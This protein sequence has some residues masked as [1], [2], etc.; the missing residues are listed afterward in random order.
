MERV[1]RRHSTT[2]RMCIDSTMNSSMSGIR[3][4]LTAG[5][6]VLAL[7]LLVLGAVLMHGVI[8]HSPTENS[9]SSAAA[10]SDGHEHGSD[11]RVHASGARAQALYGET[12]VLTTVDSAGCDGLCGLMCSLMGMACIIVIALFAWTVL[13]PRAG[14]LLHLLPRLIALTTQLPRRVA[15]PRPPSALQVIRI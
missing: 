13:R 10:L 5:T 4:L 1:A 12:P 7:L 9:T 6:A 14:G 3:R 2:T 11:S 15:V 8:G